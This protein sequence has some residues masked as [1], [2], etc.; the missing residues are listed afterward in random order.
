MRYDDS[1]LKFGFTVIKSDGEEKLQCVLCCTV[2]ASTSLKL[3]KLKRH[4]EKHD[5]NSL[6]KNVDFFKHKVEICPDLINQEC[7]GKTLRMV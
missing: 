2:L 5:P 3:S 4:F 7:F 6:N 1:Y